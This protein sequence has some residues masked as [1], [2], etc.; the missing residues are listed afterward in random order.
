MKVLKRA[1][2]RWLKIAQVIG[3]FQGQVFLTVFYFVLVLPFG[4]GVAFFS[5]PMNMKKAGR[6]SNFSKW[7]HEVDSLE[8]ARRQ[9]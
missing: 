9:F 6:G 5:D 2:K 4:I 3:N 7:K 1:W 8:T